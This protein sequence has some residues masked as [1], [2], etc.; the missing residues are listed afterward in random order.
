METKKVVVQGGG[1]N[2]FQVT[3]YNGIFSVYK[4]SVGIIFNN[5]QSIG[6]TRRFEEA[7]SIIRS[8]SGHEIE[9]IDAW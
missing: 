2:L 6:K 4:V 7:L 3:H 1:S 9:S 8:Y 5:Y